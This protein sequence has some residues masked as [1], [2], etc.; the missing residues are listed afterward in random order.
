MNNDKLTSMPQSLVG[1]FATVTNKL[2]D[3]WYTDDVQNSTIKSLKIR[4]AM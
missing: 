1:A 4:K 3:E 2:R